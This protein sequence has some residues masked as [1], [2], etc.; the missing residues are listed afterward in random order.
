M[1][2]F[3]SSEEL[4]I[5]DAVRGICAPYAEGYARSK[6]AEGKPPTELW[7]ALAEAGFIGIRVAPEWGGGGAGI[8]E[9]AVVVEEVAAATGTLPGMVVVS[10]A[11]SGPILST[12]GTESQKERWLRGIADGTVKMA[13]AVTES[14]AGSNTHELR[15]ELR[16]DGEG[17]R[18]NGSKT[19]ISA[20]EDADAILVIARM[21]NADGTLG[22]PTL[23]VVDVDCVGFTRKPIPMQF[24]GPEQQ[25]QLFFDDIP[26]ESDRLIGGENGGL[27]VLFDGLN[28]ERIIGAAIACGIARRALEKAASYARDREVWGVPI[29]S[30]QGIA[31]PLAEAKISLELARLMMQKAAALQDARACGAGEAANIAKYA[32]AEAALQAVD[33]AVQAHGGNGLTIEYGVSDLWF[34]ARLARIAPISREMIL[35]FVAQHS[36][37]LPRSY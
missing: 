21:R 16:R 32:G 31:H 1:S 20:V 5:R 3:P 6:H 29:G 37:K 11:I 23:V 19:F 7:A 4:A 13:F 30:H 12:H 35:N 15:T 18:L 10:A 9:L 27:P 24:I 2:L 25:W 17:Y 33:A 36:L 26:I 8:S 22:L 28:P 14:D 34:A